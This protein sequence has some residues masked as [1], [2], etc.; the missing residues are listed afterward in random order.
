[1]INFLIALLIAV[2]VGLVLKSFKLSNYYDSVKD[3]VITDNIFKKLLPVIVVF[4]VSLFFNP[5]SVQRIPSDKYGLKI[6]RFG[7]NK[8]L[9]IVNT[10][11]GWVFYNTYLTDVNEYER[12]NRHIEFAEFNVAA[13]GGTIISVEPSFNMAV[14]KDALPYIYVHLTKSEDLSDID[15]TFI[16]NATNIALT[17]ATNLFSPDSIFNNADIYRREVEKQLNVTLGKY[18]DIEQVKPGQTPPK[19]MVGILQAKANS[20]QAQ[21]QALLDRQTAD[22]QAYTKVAQ[23]RGDSAALV[24]RAAGD[25]EAIRLKTKEISENYVQYVKWINASKDVPR[26]PQTMLGNGTSVLLNK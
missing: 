16:S 8:G 11:S 12:K 26:V 25:A 14:K 13:K 15:Q 1:M 23:A 24:I 6:D 19:S 10:T 2:L 7:T 20:V 22:A 18:F 9:P 5:I 17:N 4:L 3:E 21:Q